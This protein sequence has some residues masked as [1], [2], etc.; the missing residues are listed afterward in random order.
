MVNGQLK[1]LENDVMEKFDLYCEWCETKTEHVVWTEEDSLVDRIFAAIITVGISELF[2]GSHSSTECREC[3][4]CGT[5]NE[6]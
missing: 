4:E 2:G 5:Y 6:Y 3:T 1:N